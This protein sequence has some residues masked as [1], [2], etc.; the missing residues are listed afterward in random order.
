[1]VLSNIGISDVIDALKNKGDWGS[2]I[3]RITPKNLTA[4]PFLVVNLVRK[5][6][7]VVGDDMGLTNYGLIFEVEIWNKNLNN[8]ALAGLKQA[9]ISTIYS[10]FPA[11]LSGEN[12]LEEGDGIMRAVLEFT[13]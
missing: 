4:F 8:N 11:H 9:V 10:S 12:E 2:R 1:M 5:T 7:L 6:D 13:I 3:Y